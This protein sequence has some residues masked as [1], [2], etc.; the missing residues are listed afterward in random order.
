MPTSFIAT[1]GEELSPCQA[2]ELTVHP[3]IGRDLV[4]NIPR[5]EGVA[6]IIAYQGKCFN[7]EGPPP[8]G[9]QGK[10]IPLG[11][12]ILKLALD[13]DALVCTGSTPARAMA[14]MENR[15]GW[16]DQVCSPGC[17]TYWKPP[18]P[19]SSAS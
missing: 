5:L 7:G 11:S 4:K 19:R 17:A 10:A 8:D 1:S 9:R 12:R 14:E 15:V 18:R 13:F 16:Y 3:L 6:E 2:K